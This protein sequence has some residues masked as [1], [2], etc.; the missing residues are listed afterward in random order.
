MVGEVEFGDDEEMGLGSDEKVLEDKY[1]D[2]GQH[3]DEEGLLPRYHVKKMRS[4]EIIQKPLFGLC[5]CRRGL[6]ELCVSPYSI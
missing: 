3:M 6:T 1:R 5:D 2:L 4:S